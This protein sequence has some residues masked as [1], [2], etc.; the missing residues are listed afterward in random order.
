MAAAVLVA[1][2]A[3]PSH[4]HDNR[5]DDGTGE[6]VPDEGAADCLREG[7]LERKIVNTHSLEVLWQ[8]RLLVLGMDKL[9][10]C[11]PS[12][13]QYVYDHI[14]LSEIVEVNALSGAF[15]MIEGHSCENVVGHVVTATTVATTPSGGSKKALVG[16]DSWLDHTAG[17][18]WRVC[19]YGS[20]CSK[21]ECVGAARTQAEGHGLEWFKRSLRGLAPSKRPRDEQN[22][23]GRGEQERQSS[24]E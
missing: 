12:D 3:G 8:Q 5:V 21:S 4:R 18:R 16:E 15:S 1:R 11:K 20:K 17:N 6:R 2:K 10:L 24:L 7:M 23:D 9:F 14:P 22:A 13:R 19:P